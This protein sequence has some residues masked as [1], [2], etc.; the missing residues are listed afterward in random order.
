MKL[1]VLSLI[2]GILVG[3]A[4]LWPA[5]SQAM[6]GFRGGMGGG[7]FRG[8]MMGGGF[9]GGMIG[10][11][12]LFFHGGNFAGR[13]FPVTAFHRQR[14]GFGANRRFAFFPHRR[15]FVFFG[16]PQFFPAAFYG[17]GYAGGY[18]SDYAADYGADYCVWQK[19]PVGYHA[20]RWRQVC[21]NGGY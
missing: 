1:N 6:G 8:G 11:R 14:I 10:N 3:A 19:V 17:A 15:R 16:G 18:G 4:T 7:G 13:S 12:V 9:R 20:W 2:A 5:E 21:A